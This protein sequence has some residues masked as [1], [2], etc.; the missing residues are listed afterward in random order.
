MLQRYN[1]LIDNVQLIIENNRGKG[2]N[3]GGVFGG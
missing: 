3:F 1:F 2:V